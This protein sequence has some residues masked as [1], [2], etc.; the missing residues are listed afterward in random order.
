MSAGVEIPVKVTAWVDE[1]VAPLVM[2]LNEIDGVVTVASS[3]GGPGRPAY[4]RLRSHDGDLKGLAQWLARLLGEHAGNL[5]QR[6]RVLRRDRGADEA[7]LL[8]LACPAPQA[9]SLAL[10][11]RAGARERPQRPAIDPQ[12]RPARDPRQP[13][14]AARRGAG[15]AGR[16]GT[17]T[18][19][20]RLRV[21]AGAAAR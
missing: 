19:P 13:V 11:L 1:G 16:A 17:S 10:A 4:V 12:Q 8:E 15:A 5:G 2:A 6:L 18:R 20:A 3:E 14:R 21:L 7:P 9:L